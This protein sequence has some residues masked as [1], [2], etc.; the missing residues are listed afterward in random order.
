MK[1]KKVVRR[2]KH[3]VLVNVVMG[4]TTTEFGVISMI[5]SILDQYVIHGEQFV[6]DRA[7]VRSYTGKRRSQIC[8]TCSRDTKAPGFDGCMISNCPR[9]YKPCL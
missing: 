1:Q 2:K 7:E 6:I 8:T 9:G 4:T 3:S 5:Q